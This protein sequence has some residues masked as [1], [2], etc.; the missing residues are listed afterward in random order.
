[1]H[2]RARAADAH[3]RERLEAGPEDAVAHAE[4]PGQDRVLRRRKLENR[5]RRAARVEAE[6]HRRAQPESAPEKLE[7]ELDGLVDL[8]DPGADQ[9]LGVGGR[10]R[11]S[12][13]ARS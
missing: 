1:M 12:R 11:V 3:L 2:A 5:E 7:R 13:L 9:A 10:W 6:Q 8:V 4:R